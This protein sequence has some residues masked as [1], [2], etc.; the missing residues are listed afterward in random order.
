MLGADPRHDI[1]TARL[2]ASRATPGNFAYVACTLLVGA[3]IAIWRENAALWGALLVLQGALGFH[4]RSLCRHFESRYPRDPVQWSR[5][6]RLTSLGLAVTWGLLAVFCMQRY[7]VGSELVLVLLVTTGLGGGVIS[8]LSADLPLVV[9]VLVTILGLPAL[10]SLALPPPQDLQLSV[11]FVIYL[12]YG[13]SQAR[14][15]NRQFRSRAGRRRPARVAIA[16]TGGGQAPGRGSQRSEEPLPGQHEPR[17]PHAH[18][19][20]AGHDRVGAGHRD[21]AGAARVPRVGP[22]LGTQPPGAGERPARLLAHRGRQARTGSAG[23]RRA[24]PGRARGRCARGGEC[25]GSRAG[26]LEGRRV[27]AGPLPARS[28]SPAAGLHQPARQRH[29]VHAQRAAS[30]SVCGQRRATTAAAGCWARSRTRGSASRPTRS[31]PSSASSRRP[32]ARSHASSAARDSGWRSRVS[33]S[34]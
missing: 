17:D 32:T 15:Q 6:F 3:L 19:R 5:D 4:R 30:R 16:R 7:G 1:R 20:A 23:Y 29:Q 18:Q 26:H 12:A 14:I 10:A 11:M 13:L 2:L 31:R 28:A 34:N 24:Q 27:G 8:A 25:R 33:W 21:D 22:P 9:P